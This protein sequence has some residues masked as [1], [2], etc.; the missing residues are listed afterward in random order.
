ML[1]GTHPAGYALAVA[2]FC[3]GASLGGFLRAAGV[4]DC[5]VVLVDLISSFF[6]LF[7]TAA[8][9]AFCGSAAL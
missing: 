8:S 5:E 1:A 6:G 9:S 4:S 2:G 3:R 7:F